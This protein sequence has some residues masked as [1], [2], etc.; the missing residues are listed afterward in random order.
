M[1]GINTDEL[2]LSQLKHINDKKMF[3]NKTHE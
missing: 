1:K 2:K 3:V